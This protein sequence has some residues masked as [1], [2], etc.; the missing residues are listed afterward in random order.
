MEVAGTHSGGSQPDPDQ[1]RPGPAAQPGVSGESSPISTRAQPAD[2]SSSRTE[3]DAT[4]S[5]TLSPTPSASPARPQASSAAPSRDD[6]DLDSPGVAQR[7]TQIRHRALDSKPVKTAVNGALGPLAPLALKVSKSRANTWLVIAGLLLPFSGLI[8]TL[9]VLTLIIGSVA[10]GVEGPGETDSLDAAYVSGVS[11][12]ALNVYQEVA[13]TTGIPWE[14]LAA[15]PAVR[16]NLTSS[17][18]DA[19]TSADATAAGAGET[20]LPHVLTTAERNSAKKQGTPLGPDAFVLKPLEK[21]VTWQVPGHASTMPRQGTY[22]Y[23]TTGYDS[24]TALER[25]LNDLETS[26]SLTAGLLDSLL[27]DKHG[28]LSS[29]DLDTGVTTVDGCGS[30]QDDASTTSNTAT[31]VLTNADE[32]A[33][34]SATNPYADD[35][36]SGSHGTCDPSRSSF[37]RRFDTDDATEVSASQQLASGD[38]PK[39]AQQVK[40]A[41]I[42]VLKRLPIDRASDLAE[43]TYTKAMTWFF[44]I[45][46]SCTQGASA[47]ATASVPTTGGFSFAVGTLNVLGE[48]HTDPKGIDDAGK[49][50]YPDYLTRGPILASGITESGVS[51]IGTQETTANQRKQFKTLL[52]GWKWIGS[53]AG[54]A[55][56]YT[57]GYDA[58]KWTKTSLSTLTVPWIGSSTQQAPV[59]GLTSTAAAGVAGQQVYVINVHPTAPAYAGSLKDRRKN[60]RTVAA[61][62]EALNAAAPNAAVVVTGDFNADMAGRT[63]EV[64]S[65]P[66][67]GDLGADNS[68]AVMLKKDPALHSADPN[69]AST[70]LDYIF[71]DASITFSAP[72]Y[73]TDVHTR[74]GTDHP[75]LVAATATV[76]P[77]ATSSSASPTQADTGTAGTP[78][79]TSVFSSTTP[80]TQGAAALDA[81]QTANA[82]TIIATAATVFPDQAQ[83]AAVVGIDVALDE[84]HLHD[85]DGGTGSSVGVFQQIASWGTKAERMDVAWAANA[86]FTALKSVPGWDTMQVWAAAQAVQRSG[87]GAASGG[88][89]N[90]G[91]FVAQA[92]QIVSQFAG[93]LSGSVSGATAANCSA[94]A[95]GTIVIGTLNALGANH[96]APCGHSGQHA[97]TVDYGDAN[98]GHQDNPIYPT[99][100]ARLDTVMSSIN[101]DG[102]GVV[103]LQE[104]EMPQVNYFLK[105][106]GDQWGMYPGG[107]EPQSARAQVQNSVIWNKSAWDVVTGAD[108]KPVESMVTYPYRF[109][110]TGYGALV[111]LKSVSTGATVWV[112]NVHNPANKAGENN[113]DDRAASVSKEIDA[114]TKVRATDPDSPILFTGDMNASASSKKSNGNYTDFYC[115]FTTAATAASLD[116]TAALTAP[117]TTSGSDSAA[118]TQP[119]QGAGGECDPPKTSTIDWILGNG[120]MQWSGYTEDPSV[121]KKHGTDHP[122]LNYATA[123]FAGSGAA[124]STGFGVGQGEFTAN[125]TVVGHYSDQQLWT[126]AQ[127]YAAATSGWIDTGLSGSYSTSIDYTEGPCQHFVANLSGYATSGYATARVGWTHYVL[128]GQAHLAGTPDGMSPPIGAELYYDT[129]NPDGHVVIY[130]GDNKVISSDMGT[131]GKNQPGHISIVDESAVRAWGSYLG[132]A[133]P[134]FN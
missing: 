43:Q 127:K 101:A 63:Y 19:G 105:K 64:K 13:A 86:F 58:S 52:P 78:T 28:D 89:A 113:A 90:Y 59:L 76:A 102:I 112:L 118:A 15:I 37:N 24:G 7:I 116:F 47:P 119:A 55:N 21:M 84:S 99:Y 124:G 3:P 126:R 49:L 1:S 5:P 85:L 51:I 110:Q 92:Q 42:D 96:T 80:S 106:Y 11:E 122:S 132:W 62:V 27:K 68:I 22:S 74:K 23:V 29:F 73:V 60:A 77:A 88:E 16:G 48:S 67:A 45:N 39:A 44:G 18:T 65:G 8:I 108:G 70:S 111:E 109:N 93:S 40:A 115:Q 12:H 50:G 6:G 4:L 25:H 2:P 104:F 75:A 97:C 91:Q 34:A 94:G 134:N 71:G 20:T 82:K 128:T 87:A 123:T 30:S 83:Q 69:T 46:D 81:D 56:E 131:D 9:L 129:S 79:L 32:P 66:T 36:Y 114:F 133:P 103:G 54:V 10:G 107:V 14:I 120:G 33:G 121:H 100:K 98:A 61:E 41:W 26:A 95:G 125:S 117:A 17:G 31:T 57:I 72:N 38:M 130:L 35:P 53:N